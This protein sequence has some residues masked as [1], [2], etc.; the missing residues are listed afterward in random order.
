M[1][2]ISKKVGFTINKVA[3]KSTRVKPASFHKD[4]K[5]GKIGENIFKWIVSEGRLPHVGKV[6]DMEDKNEV[7][8]YRDADI[9]FVLK[10]SKGIKTVEVKTDMY[11]SPNMAYEY[12]DEQ[13]D[14]YYKWGCLE[15]T[16]A[17]YLFYVFPLTRLFLFVD[18]HSLREWMKL[19]ID[20]EGVN[21]G[22]QKRQLKKPPVFNIWKQS[23]VLNIPLK[24]IVEG[25]YNTRYKSY[26]KPLGK[27]ILFDLDTSIDMFASKVRRGNSMK[28]SKYYRLGTLDSRVLSIK[29]EYMKYVETKKEKEK[30][31]EKEAIKCGE[32]DE[33]SVMN[34]F[35]QFST[36]YQNNNQLNVN[37][38]E[39]E[40]NPVFPWVDG[41]IAN[42]IDI[43]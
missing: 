4:V 40:V 43:I 12:I 19:R 16:K 39:I 5:R 8:E 34:E 14:K 24:E 9:D 17:D 28:N 38:N 33:E 23:R 15:K 13:T 29:K 37:L 22:Q 18:M 20:Y 26:I 21:D 41:K 31:L 36:L 10:T 35:A 7:K 3:G 6:Y 11:A 1:V 30:L 27:D 32:T 2:K 42:K 25:Y